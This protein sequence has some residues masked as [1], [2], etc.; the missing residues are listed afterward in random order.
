MVATAAAPLNPNDPI[1]SVNVILHSTSLKAQHEHLQF[2][3]QLKVKGQGLGRGVDP[4]KKSRGDNKMQ[5]L[6]ES[7][8]W[9]I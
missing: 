6:T 7:N 9:G 8:L 3:V 1:P 4:D 5:K 2:S